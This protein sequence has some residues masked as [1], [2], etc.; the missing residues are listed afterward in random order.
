MARLKDKIAV[1]TGAGM[2][3]GQ[4]MALLLAAKVPES[5]SLTSMTQRGEKR[6]DKSTIKG[7]KP[8]LLAA[9][10][11]RLTTLSI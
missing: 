1:I 5:S 10:S 6:S 8:F 11:R 4:S 7:A 3:L 9:I 2:G